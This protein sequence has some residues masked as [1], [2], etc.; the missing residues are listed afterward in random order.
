MAKYELQQRLTED[1]ESYDRDPVEKYVEYLQEKGNL[2][3]IENL[4]FD[5][6]AMA[7][8]FVCHTAQ[9]MPDKEKGKGR[10]KKSS[11]CCVVYGPRVSTREKERIE[12]IL[13]GLTE[14][15]PD[16]RSRVAKLDGFYEWDE[17]Y[18]RLLTKDSK[19]RC[20]FLGETEEDLAELIGPY[21]CRIHSYCLENNL[22]PHWYKPSACVMFP[23]FLLDVD[24]D[25]G[26]MFITCHSEEV[27]NLGEDEDNH[28]DVGCLKKHA[29]P[30]EPLYVTMKGTLITMFGEEVWQRLD[31]EMQEYSG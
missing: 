25:E 30:A 13:E 11:S 31:Q 15:F 4:Y 3:Q 17:E 8:S 24:T 16:V 27:M 12:E 5:A 7:R 1:T 21:S 14:R 28:H 26:T 10:K 20:V 2:I 22:D 9:C 19:K 29:L 6:D 23:L 18:D